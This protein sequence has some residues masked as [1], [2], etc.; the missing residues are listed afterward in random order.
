MMLADPVM[1]HD[2]YFMMHRLSGNPHLRLKAEHFPGL[3]IICSRIGYVIN[4]AID[5][6][7]KGAAWL[8]HPHVWSG[9]PRLEWNPTS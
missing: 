6:E 2:E 1:M 4:I 3:R 7:S 9:I 5:E 8:P